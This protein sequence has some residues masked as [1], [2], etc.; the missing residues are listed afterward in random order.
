MTTNRNG[1]TGLDAFVAAEVRAEIARVPGASVKAIA[2]HLG[3]RRATLSARVNG[4]VPF[5]ASLLAAVAAELG[6]SASSIVAKAEALL[7]TARTENSTTTPS[8]LAAGAA[9]EIGYAA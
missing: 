2:E 1:V 3:M 8:A 7:S 5:S 6:N 4:H 9:P